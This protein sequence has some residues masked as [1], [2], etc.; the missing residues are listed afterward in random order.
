MTTH[1]ER[2]EA[3][4]SG[5]DTDRTPVA[6]WRHFPGDDQDPDRLAA[7]TLFWQKNYDWD[8]VKVTP[9][10]SFALK[11][12]GVDFDNLLMK[13]PAYDIYY[14]DKSVNID[15]YLPVPNKDNKGTKSKKLGVEIVEK[16]WGREVIFVNNDE[17][18]GKLL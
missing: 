6:L 10:S 12:W 16:G 17:Y 13:K 15:T 1:R 2:M 5:Q 4:V 11:D 8:V 7:A 18:C 14:D 9:A 3:L